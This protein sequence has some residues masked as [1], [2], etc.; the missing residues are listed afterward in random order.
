[1]QE[2]G[3]TM[4][5]TECFLPNLFLVINIKGLNQFVRTKHLKPYIF[6]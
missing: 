5:L 6:L 1:M 3:H 2:K 4:E